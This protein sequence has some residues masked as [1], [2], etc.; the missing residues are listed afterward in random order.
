M[1]AIT[2]IIFDKQKVEFA[3]D[4]LTF[5]I[6]NIKSRTVSTFY[7]HLRLYNLSDSLIYTY[8]S[9][10]WVISNSYHTRY[11]TFNIPSKYVDKVAYMQL[12]LI[13]VGV[14]SE[15]PLYF[16]ELMLNE[17]GYKKYHDNS[18]KKK[19]VKI[20]FNKSSYAILYNED[21]NSLQVIR[22]SQG[23]IFTSKIT[24]SEVTILAPHLEKEIE[25]D[26][27]IN[28]FFEYINQREQRVDVLR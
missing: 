4:E 1:S 5:S 23:D 16:N 28:L 10:R 24:A 21:G 27:P 7:F 12:E 19:S 3:D 20:K 18:S 9:D 2:K 22:P 15:N 8:T 6:G 25:E 26:N 14:S 13:A 11:V 17:G